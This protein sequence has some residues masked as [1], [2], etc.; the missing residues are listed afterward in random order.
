MLNILLA[1]TEPDASDVFWTFILGAILVATVIVII[2]CLYHYSQ[3]SS[4]ENAQ[5]N[6]KMLE[7]EEELKK[8]KNKD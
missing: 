5:I 7:L 2:I 8:M 6:A 1:E 3:R 4:Q